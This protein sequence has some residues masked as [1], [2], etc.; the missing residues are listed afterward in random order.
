MNYFRRELPSLLAE[1]S[2]FTRILTDVVRGSD[3]PDLRQATLFENELVLYQDP[4]RIFSLRLYFFS[5]EEHTSVHDHTSWGVSGSAFGELEIVRYRRE[6]DGSN[7]DQA[8]LALSE[9]IVLWP[10]ET[11]TTLPL[12]R[13]IHCTGNPSN[14]VTLMVSVY[15]PPLRRLYIQR[16]NLENGS[17]PRLF[18]GLGKDAGRAGAEGDRRRPVITDRTKMAC[19]KS[20]NCL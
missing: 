5:S 8:H 2:L 3:F 17:A 10:G 6:D 7:P 16:F 19:K 12:D 13:G 1:R 11:E 20:E 14:G 18:P 9:R 15:G 4:A